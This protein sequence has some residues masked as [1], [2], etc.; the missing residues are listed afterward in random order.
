MFTI[1]VAIGNNYEIGKNNSLLW[2][3]PDDL[4]FF[5]KITKNSKIVMGRKTFE[6]LPGRLKD[7][8]YYIITSNQEFSVNYATM[9]NNLDYFIDENKET[10]EEIFVI[11][12]GSIYKY[13]LPYVKRMYITE[14]DKCYVDAD[15][16][17]PEFDKSKWKRKLL[18][19]NFQNGISFDNILLEKI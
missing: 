9:V 11:G 5:K 19:S 17:F 4:R 16:Y 8:Q 13:F 10:E 12:G 7:R 3:L 6:S 14:V 2:Y 18:C 15:C 1:I